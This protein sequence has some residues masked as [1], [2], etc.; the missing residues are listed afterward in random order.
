MDRKSIGFLSLHLFIEIQEVVSKT[1]AQR[2]FKRYQQDSHREKT[3]FDRLHVVVPLSFEGVYSVNHIGGGRHATVYCY[4]P[5][6]TQRLKT[7][8]GSVDLLTDRLR[9][10]S[11]RGRLYEPTIQPSISISPQTM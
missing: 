8:A 4:L 1:T 10:Y 9:G 11:N 7:K 3:L 6:Q 5:L 2:R